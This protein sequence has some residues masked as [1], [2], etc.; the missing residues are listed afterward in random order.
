MQFAPDREYD[1]LRVALNLK[2]NYAKRAFRGI[3]VNTV[4]PLRDPL[5]LLTFHCG[6]NLK[7]E[8]CKLVDCHGRTLTL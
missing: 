4:K 2:V 6:P 8:A 3:V 1:L 5:T 7:V